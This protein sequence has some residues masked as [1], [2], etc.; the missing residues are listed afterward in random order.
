M[1]RKNMEKGTRF[2]ELPAAQPSVPIPIPPNLGLTGREARA[3]TPETL[4]CG[5]LLSGRVWEAQMWTCERWPTLSGRCQVGGSVRCR[6][7]GGGWLY[8]PRRVPLP[9]LLSSCASFLYSHRPPFSCPLLPDPRLAAGVP[10]ETACY[11]L[12]WGN[13]LFTPCHS[14]NVVV[15][16]GQYFRMHNSWGSWREERALWSMLL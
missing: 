13:R 4:S 15:S 16:Q 6:S 11:S 1:G 2:L 3:V 14:Q 9:P 5:L 12:C 8:F 7:W 10:V